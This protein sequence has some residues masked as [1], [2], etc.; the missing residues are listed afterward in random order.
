[1]T[2]VFILIVIVYVI[3]TY[4]KLKRRLNMEVKQIGKEDL[5][6]LFSSQYAKRM[7]ECII[8]TDGDVSSLFDDISIKLD[9]MIR[10][11]GTCKSIDDTSQWM[12]DESMNVWRIEDNPSIWCKCLSN[13]RK[14][15]IYHDNQRIQ[16]YSINSQT[17][18][19]DPNIRS[20]VDMLVPIQLPYHLDKLTA[21]IE[22]DLPKNKFI[23]KFIINMYTGEY[24]PINKMYGWV[25]TG[26]IRPLDND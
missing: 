2:A 13:N 15:M 16:L 23:I 26:L 5:S 18:I 7:Y 14:D 20:I 19:N 4:Y 12:L 9:K 1:M 6:E 3:I 11:S 24:T 21:Y 10:Y 17:Y 25:S 8:D 22:F